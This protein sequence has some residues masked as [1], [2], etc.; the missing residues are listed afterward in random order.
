MNKLSK[1]LYEKKKQLANH[2][3]TYEKEIEEEL[4]TLGMAIFLGLGLCGY[5]TLEQRIE[6]VRT[7]IAQV[8]SATKDLVTMISG[9]ELTDGKIRYTTKL[10]SCNMFLS[11]QYDLETKIPVAFLTDKEKKECMPII[12]KK[13]ETQDDK[14]LKYHVDIV[15]TAIYLGK[16]FMDSKNE[17]SCSGLYYRIQSFGMTGNKECIIEIHDSYESAMIMIIKLA[18]VQGR[19]Q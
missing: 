16:Q 7:E 3:K 6:E 1:W 18:D 9:V 13:D 5:I 17:V 14:Y 11:I 8:K 15:S 12:L 10:E 2:L 19:L 4:G